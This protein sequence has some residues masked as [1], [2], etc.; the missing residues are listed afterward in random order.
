MMSAL[1]DLRDL[2]YR[3]ME[4]DY[5][6]ERLARLRAAAEGLNSKL[7]GEGGGGSHKIPD[8]MA[9]LSAAIMDLEMLVAEKVIECELGSLEVEKALD[10]LPPDQK[11][12]MRLRYVRALRW[13]DVAKEAGYSVRQCHRLYDNAAVKLSK[14]ETAP[15]SK[16]V[17]Q[18]H[19]NPR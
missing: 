12:I 8:K 15:S 10:A 2:K 16:D 11:R 13:E 5:Y 9:Q 19:I 1:D 6:S 7:G 17:T 4:S 3:R 18:C 14:A